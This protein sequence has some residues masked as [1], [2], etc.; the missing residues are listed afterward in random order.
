MTN[1]NDRESTLQRIDTF[2]DEFEA[3]WRRGEQPDIA[4]VLSRVPAGER[5]RLCVELVRLDI[6]YRRKRGEQPRTADYAHLAGWD[7]ELARLVT[8]EQPT[9][10]SVK[11]QPDSV[12]APPPLAPTGF[13]QLVIGERFGPYQLL[14]KL[15]QGGMGA[16]YKVRHVRLG[17]TMALKIMAADLMQQADAV[18]R[19]ER[20]M[21]AVGQV[22]H[23][24]VVQAHDAGE[25]NG[26]HYLAL[27]YV[28]GRDLQQLIREQGPLS[29]T[30]ACQA[31]RQAALGLVAAHEHGLV[32]RD[33]K[34]A[35]LFATTK[36]QVKIL[37]LGLATLTQGDAGLTVSGECFGSPDYMPPEQWENP[38]DCDARSDLYAL[39]CTL[40]TLLTG[41]PPFG[42]ESYHSA[43]RKMMGHVRDAVP[44]LRTGCPAVPAALNSLFQKLMAK[45]PGDRIAT[46]AELVRLLTP[47]V[48][49]KTGEE[50]VSALVHLGPPG[51]A[52]SRAPGETTVPPLRENTAILSSQRAATASSS[53]EATRHKRPANSVVWFAGIGLAASLALG[54]ILFFM[55]GRTP[56][57]QP[58]PNTPAV[59]KTEPGTSALNP[60]PVPF[61]P[62]LPVQPPSPPAADRALDRQVAELLLKKEA[63]VRVSVD[64][65]FIE[66]VSP[67]ALP[68]KPFALV[69]IARS[70][71]Q[72]MSSQELAECLQLVR[73][74][75]EL[76]EAFVPSSQADQWATA[77]AEVASV[78]SLNGYRSDLSDLGL[79]EL[80]RFPQLQS[81][82]LEGCNQYTAQGARE[83]GMIR[84]LRRLEFARSIEADRLPLSELQWLQDQL[85][86]CR[87]QFAGGGAIPGLRPG[88]P[89]NL[90]HHSAE[91]PFNYD[92]AR[93]YQQEWATYFGVPVEYTSPSKIKFVLIPPGE[94]MMGSSPAE[95]EAA[96]QALQQAHWEPQHRS[97][98]PRHRVRITRPF[99]LGVHEVTQAQY[100]AIMNENPSAH[101]STGILKERV[102]GL[103]TANFPVESIDWNAASSY[104]QKVTAND[105]IL[106]R[107]PTEAEWEFACRAG[108][109]T[110]FWS[111]ADSEPFQ[112]TANFSPTVNCGPV[113][114]FPRNPF[115]L[116]GMHTNVREW[117]SDIWTPDYFARVATTT[118]IN[119]TGP[120]TPLDPHPPR[121]SKGGSFYNGVTESRSASRYGN[122]PGSLAD[123]IGFRIVASVM[124]VKYQLA[125]KP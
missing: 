14:A 93:E 65:E 108:T 72:E 7:E 83:L 70:I 44:D 109:E 32:H 9:S 41:A 96:L 88:L 62:Q 116:R 94:F 53:R 114:E 81:V 99:Y 42:G 104:C 71:Q 77:F 12:K 2:C 29:A 75:K 59:N 56:H 87:I 38:R 61:A 18:A 80:V 119:P 60:Q 6:D 101:S 67:S 76:K 123:A 73:Q 110:W 45:N 57:P 107:L 92:R 10:A 111:G 24:N 66:V 102:K 22:Q 86:D 52:A 48:G 74:L 39:G 33:I 100:A 46:A 118:S 89:N 113:D 95:I 4:D 23:P 85:P 43:P 105:G 11:A 28:E 124:S 125:K 55:L 68:D 30:S 19:F 27:E 112:R 21:L 16:V 8:G 20:E 34:P 79:R 120:V 49:G 63:V 58:N 78:S 15:G 51:S 36:G 122:P 1:Q 50:A 91:A 121:V 25:V 26:V 31:I 103:D 84:E 47:F 106:C 17:K 64:G 54:A 115:G 37:D 69:E 117:V 13:S 98:G 82:Y 35:N 40:H 5:R 90:P 97:E 3:A